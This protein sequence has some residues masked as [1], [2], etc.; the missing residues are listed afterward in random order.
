LKGTAVLLKAALAQRVDRFV[1]ISTDEVYGDLAAGAFSDEDS[2]IRPNS[3]YAA[4]KAGS[5]LLVR[6][7]VK[8]FRLPAIITR[9]SNNYGPY[10]CPEKFLPLMIT[11]ALE[12][13]SLP[14]YGDGKQQR[15]WVHVQDNCRGIYAVLE[16][17]RVGE[18]YNLGG[19]DIEENISMARRILAHT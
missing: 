9:S 10:Q 12:N 14:I 16:K 18:I 8:T 7:Y 3:P 11:N 15:D 13:K 2:P 5:D 17:G 6:S 4:S 1:H 19:L